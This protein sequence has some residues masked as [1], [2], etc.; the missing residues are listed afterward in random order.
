MGELEVPAYQE[1]L[2]TFVTSRRLFDARISIKLL[3]DSLSSVLVV[4][5]D[6]KQVGLTV[7]QTTNF[8]EKG[9]Q[10]PS[11]DDHL[12]GDA[13]KLDPDFVKSESLRMLISPR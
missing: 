6:G 1:G 3:A 7:V 10:T 13:S 12:L 8:S 5:E 9:S 11:K 2:H 4:D